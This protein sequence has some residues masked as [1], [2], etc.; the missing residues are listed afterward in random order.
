MNSNKSY[1][2]AIN[3]K[4]YLQ[5]VNNNKNDKYDKAFQKYNKTTDYVN[6]DYFYKSKKYKYSNKQI[7]INEQLSFNCNLKIRRMTN[8]E[9]DL[10][11]IFWPNYSFR[12]LSHDAKCK[13]NYDFKNK[14][15]KW[16]DFYYNN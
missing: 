13:K 16:F 12:R 2:Q 10:F 7:N 9:K 5:A 3:N 6:M 14:N 1:L 4:S 15:K 8:K 11:Q